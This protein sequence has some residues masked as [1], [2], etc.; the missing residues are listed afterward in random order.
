MISLVASTVVALGAT[1]TYSVNV[2]TMYGW[3]TKQEFAQAERADA[4]LYESH[5]DYLQDKITRDQRNDRQD[6][7]IKAAEGRSNEILAFVKVVPQLKVMLRIR[8]QG[9]S[10]VQPTIDELH[11]Q[12]RDLTGRDYL[13]P[14]CSDP[15][16][17]PTP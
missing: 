6:A 10:G 8:C 17:R 16:L 15:E 11:R 12:F 3:V 2:Y 14:H 9:N 13:E 5:V 7:E 1:V 4:L